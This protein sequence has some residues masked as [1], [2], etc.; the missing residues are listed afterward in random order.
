MYCFST[1]YVWVFAVISPPCLSLGHDHLSVALSHVLFT[2]PNSRHL[3][4]PRYLFSLCRYCPSETSLYCSP[5]H[6]SSCAFSVLRHSRIPLNM[7][8]SLRLRLSFA[9]VLYALKPMTV[10]VNFFFFLLFSF[11]DQSVDTLTTQRSL[12][13]YS[14]SILLQT[15]LIILQYFFRRR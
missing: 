8:H 4:L 5:Y 6:L 2:C 13:K 10:V 12:F 9:E 3:F 15:I 11:I 14:I 1:P 7:P